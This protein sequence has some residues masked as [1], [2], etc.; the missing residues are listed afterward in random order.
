[1]RAAEREPRVEPPDTCEECGRVIQTTH[2]LVDETHH[3]H[4]HCYAEATP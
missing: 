1:M 3:F 4:L 2:V